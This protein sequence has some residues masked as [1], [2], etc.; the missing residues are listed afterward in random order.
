MK[1][2]LIVPPNIGF[3]D[4]I[5]PPSNVKISTKGVERKKYGSIITD[6]PLGIISLSAY[7]KSK[8][9]IQTRGIDFNVLLK[10]IVSLGHRLKLISKKHYNMKSMTSNRM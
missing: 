2:L 1:I 5:S 9:D 7:L 3:T 8:I 6:M 4:F 10:S